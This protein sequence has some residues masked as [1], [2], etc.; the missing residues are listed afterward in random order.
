MKKYGLFPI[1]ITV[2][3]EIVAI[4][5]RSYLIHQL[6]VNVVLTHMIQVNNNVL[7]CNFYFKESYL[8][9]N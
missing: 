2:D 8:K 5:S 4:I 6:N 9:I 3:V 1:A 7:L